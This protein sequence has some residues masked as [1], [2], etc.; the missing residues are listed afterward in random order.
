MH[1]NTRWIAAGALLFLAATAGSKDL[2]NIEGRPPLEKI[3]AYL[4]LL[5]TEEDSAEVLF[6]LGNAYHDA[7]MIE[8]AV[9]AYRRS[10]AAGGD[11]RVFVNM[12]FVLE[13]AG[14]RE[15]ADAVYRERIKQTP[16]DPVLFAYYGDFLS[17]DEN[18]KTSVSGAMGAYRQALALDERCLEAH[19]GLG[20]LF[21]KT[22]IYKEAV[23]EWEHVMALSPQHRLAVE[24]RR[25]IDRVRREQ[26][27]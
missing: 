5:G 2:G 25:N 23:R 14:R 16:D 8:E 19:F 22:G 26:G 15:E 13:G 6:R 12:T 4:A 17:G 3:D 11:F 20:V 27:R 7:E 18:E 9:D 24:S 21:A 1:S 10:L